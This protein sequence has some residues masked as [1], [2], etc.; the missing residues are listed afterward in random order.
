MC[1]PVT[2][3]AAAPHQHPRSPRESVMLRAVVTCFGGATP[4]EHRV[5]DLSSGGI[6]IDQADALKAGAT[7]LVSV[8]AL[9]AVGATVR[10]VKD[11]SA[12]LAFAELIEPAA[13]RTRA[14]IQ[15]KPAAA[16]GRLPVRVASAA[17]A[18]KGSAPAR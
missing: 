5:R 17:A 3:P 13:A 14:S 2:D 4:S 15:R 6:R 9:E 7:V 12:G 11:G 8:G 18:A 1:R 10:W 16:G